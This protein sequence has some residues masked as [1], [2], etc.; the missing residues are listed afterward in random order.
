MSDGKSKMGIIV[1][2]IVAVCFAVGAIITATT[3]KADTPAEQIVEAVLKTQGI[4]YDFSA[5]KKD[6][7]SKDD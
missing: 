2:G 4:D 3:D 1:L 5:S 6:P 7:D